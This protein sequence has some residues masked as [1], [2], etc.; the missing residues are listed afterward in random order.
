MKAIEYYKYL[1]KCDLRV[2]EPA[3]LPS[4]SRCIAVIPACDEL[5]TIRRTLDSLKPL[6]GCAVLVVVNHPEDAVSRIKESSSELLRRF[7]GGFFARSDLHWIEAPDLN[8]GVG[9]AR[10]LGMD[11]VV[12]SQRPESIEHTVI[13]SL[14]AD[15]VVES[16]Y[17]SEVLRAFER[18]PRIA[19]LSI[20]LSHLPGETPEEDRAIRRYE[21]YLARYV[22]KLRE[23]GSPYA[24]Q[25]VGSAFAVRL[26]IYVRAGGMRIRR[27]GED[28]YFLQ[29]VAKIG[30]VGTG[31][32]ILVHPSARPSER[33]PFGT[34]PA[35]RKLMAGEKLSEI[36]DRAFEALGRL[37]IRVKEAGDLENA[38]Q[39]LQKLD[40][41]CAFFLRAEGF[42][43]I[44]PKVLVNTP[45]RADA[46]RAAFH[47]WFD[48]LRTLRCL[49]A[50]D[51]R[52]ADSAEN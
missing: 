42:P 15:T 22:A 3:P 1:K 51:R 28:F 18:A 10:R 49:H 11:A 30:P 24:F 13:A 7:R 4:G 48:G 36:S 27:G 43:V 17:F 35:V 46:R 2:V 31:D 38:E 47:R 21:A 6:P 29:A 34:G 20:P 50:F 16:D 33:V 52:A 41:E 45:K 12:A 19:A 25:T 26:D 5:E 32:K 40:P 9:E 39:F 14:D 23:A 37:L 44:W 8:G